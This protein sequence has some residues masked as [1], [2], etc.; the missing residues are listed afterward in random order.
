VWGD[1]EKREIGINAM[2]AGKDHDCEPYK[3]RGNALF[4]DGI[5]T[6]KGKGKKLCGHRRETQGEATD[7][8]R[9]DCTTTFGAG[10][11][12]GAGKK[13]PTQENGPSGSKIVEG[14][15]GHATKMTR[16]GAPHQREQR[17]TGWL[18]VKELKMS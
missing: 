8:A 16:E 6:H 3:N 17:R 5:N 13:T 11:L 9:Q 12:M 2:V 1:P 18:Q 14:T 15:P 7:Q 4:V 10:E